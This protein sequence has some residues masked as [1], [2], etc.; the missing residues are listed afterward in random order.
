[1]IDAQVV[2][3]CTGDGDVAAAAGAPYEIGRHEDGLVQPMTLMF[4]VVDF[5]QPEF[6]AYVRE[7]PDQWRGVHGLW[8]LV[9]EATR[10]GELVLPR[11]D[12][13]F[14]GT[15]HPHEVSVNSTRI[16][17]AFGTSV[18]DL[19]HAEYVARRQMEQIDRFLCTHVPGFEHSYIAQSGIQVG[20]RESRRILGDYQLTGHDILAAH[21]F[22]DVIA[23]GAYPV[24]IHNPRGTGTTLRRVPRGKAYDIP[25]R[26]LLPKDTERI[27]VGGRCISGTHVAHSSYR[28]MP[29]AMATGQAAGV[30]AALAVRLGRSPREVPAAWVQR[31]LIEQGAYI[32]DGIRAE[33]ASAPRDPTA[34]RR[35]A[36]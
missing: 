21:D 3:D 9:K 6:A 19:T 36:G 26:C 27:L 22:P 30:C 33:L 16:T 17:R 34:F 8:D 23:H 18:W 14:F 4:R 13:L 12:I 10:H 35:G 32:R 5:A 29:I 20:V 1:V 28:V 7:H 24:D 15:P 25:L 2:V 11:E 31:E